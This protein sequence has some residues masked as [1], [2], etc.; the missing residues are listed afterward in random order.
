[1]NESSTVQPVLL[2]ENSPDVRR[3]MVEWLVLQGYPVHTAING[4]D[5]LDKLRAGL[6]PCLILMHLHTP[7]M[8]GFEFRRRQLDDP[9]L[10]DI[11][12]VVYSGLYDP[13]MAAKVLNATAYL[14]TPFD[15]EVLNTIIEAHCKRRSWPSPYRKA[16]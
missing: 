7:A 2:V 3:A 16:A 5:A 11:P 4:I 10:A 14:Y 9:Q 6:R 8:N 15:I 1:M 13:Q 12:I